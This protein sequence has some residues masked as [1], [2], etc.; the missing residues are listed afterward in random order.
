MTHVA[1]LPAGPALPVHCT[2][3]PTACADDVGASRVRTFAAR[4]AVTVSS[5]PLTP[6]S[7]TTLNFPVLGRKEP[8][9]TVSDVAPAA[10]EV[11]AVPANV[12]LLL[13]ALPL[14]LSENHAPLSE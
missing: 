8:S 5:T 14:W 12:V 1:V 6:G 3:A 10:T 7:R 11:P 9:L 2:A 13:Y 4:V